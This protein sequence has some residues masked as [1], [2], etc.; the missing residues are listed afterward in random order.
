MNTPPNGLVF[1]QLL[2][3]QDKLGLRQKL[4]HEKTCVI[5]ILNHTFATFIG[6]MVCLA[7]CM[8]GIFPCFCYRLLAYF[9]INFLKFFQEHYN[10]IQTVKHFGS[11]SGQTF[12]RS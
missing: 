4:M 2:R 9:E 1:K 3:D 12:C 7:L 8:L 10:T 5:P 6:D 11:R